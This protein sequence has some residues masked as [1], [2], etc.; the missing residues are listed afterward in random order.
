MQ[1]NGRMGSEVTFWLVKSV[2]KV[3]SLGTDDGKYG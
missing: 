1:L 2:Q 3:Q